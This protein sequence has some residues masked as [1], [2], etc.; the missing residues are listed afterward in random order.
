[1]VNGRIILCLALLCAAPVVARAAQPD[2]ALAKIE[3]KEQKARAACE[4]GRLDEGVKLLAELFVQ[5]DDGNYIFNQGRC[6]QQNGQPDEAVKRFEMYLLRR[7]AEPAVSTRARQLIAD[8]RGAP[9]TTTTPPPPA[10][11]ETA[12]P[13][14]AATAPPGPGHTLRVTGL[15]LVGV[16]LAALGAATYFGL[17]L[18]PINEDAKMVAAGMPL[19]RARLNQLNDRGDRYELLQWISIGVGATAVTT[20]AVLTF[21]G[22]RADRAVAG[23]WRVSP[24]LSPRYAGAALTLSFR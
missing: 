12:M 20:G 3:G 7:D 16:G 5:T 9:A 11:I 23:A 13:P 17:S 22:V 21:L 24:V 4:S 10:Q 19:D 1:V 8:I 18:G 2:T 14:P 6:F 15:S